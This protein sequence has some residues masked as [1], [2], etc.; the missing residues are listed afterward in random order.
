[1]ST[2]TVADIDRAIAGAFPPSRAEAWDRVGLL[3][4]DPEVPV[5]GVALALDPSRSAI[6]RAR[7]AGANVLVT[8][9][10]AFLEPPA[11]IVPGAGSAGL[12]FEAVSSGVALINAHTNLDRDPRAARLLPETLGLEPL[13]PV[14][15]SPQPMALVT[16]Y[17][18]S[19]AAEDVLAEMISAG[20]GR[21]GD[22][23][24]CSFSAPGTGH[25]TP[26]AG[27][28]PAAGTPGAPSSS[29]ELRIEVIAPRPAAR[30]V[31]A[32]ATE[33]HPYEEPLVTVTEVA[34][35]RNSARLGM[36]CSAPRDM[37][38]QG[39]ATLAA[40]TFSITP[41]IWGDPGT[42]ARTVAVAT[43]SAGSLVADALSAGAQALV[44]GE[45][46]YHDAL[47]A[48]ESGLCIVELGHDVSEWPLVRLLAQAVLGVKGIDPERVSV[49][50]GNP[51]WWTP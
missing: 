34:I 19:H 38:L 13:G 18:P 8:H 30:G 11:G 49:L 33:S 16:V 51:G 25:F 36:L 27:A 46:R 35:A 20:A 3:A 40:A 32:A 31:V 24:G 15:R 5:T 48:M 23:E 7:E 43:G 47:D 45:V 21:I 50:P 6:R 1:V 12:L 28:H 17:V 29:S 37:T 44:A 26:P 4:G 10:P 42:P 41:R 2:V 9:H 22:Y 39:L 14:E